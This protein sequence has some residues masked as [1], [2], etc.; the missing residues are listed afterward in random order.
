V[1]IQAWVVAAAMAVLLSALSWLAADFKHRQAFRQ[2]LS[3]R[4][5]GDTR[6]NFGFTAHATRRLG[7]PQG[8]GAIGMGLIVIASVAF[9]A[10]GPVLAIALTTSLAAAGVA[11]RSAVERRKTERYEAALPAMLDGLTRG[12]R[13]G[14]GL[15]TAL[16]EASTQSAPEIKDEIAEVTRR[17][18]LGEGMAEALDHWRR[19]RQSRSVDICVASL[20]LALNTGGS[21]AQAIDAASETVRHAT[22]ARA[23]ASA[24]AA[25]GRM[26]ALVLTAMPL[27]ISGPVLVSNDN[28]RSFMLHSIPGA[29]ILIFGIALD[30]AGALWMSSLI[31]RSTS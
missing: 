4:R 29:A 30:L 10:S 22:N 18:R 17:V 2:L 24:H 14:A 12:L 15:L 7:D 11:V 20:T 13:S 9:A 27:V 21:Q 28:A 16:E 23:T 25:H 19:S 5:D 26:S 8:P 3:N 31:R 6:R 1:L